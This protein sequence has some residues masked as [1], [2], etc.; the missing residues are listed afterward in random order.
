MKLNR[1]LKTMV[2]IWNVLPNIKIAKSG[3]T[4]QIC[5]IISSLQC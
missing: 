1:S 5:S 4:L 2:S 3:N